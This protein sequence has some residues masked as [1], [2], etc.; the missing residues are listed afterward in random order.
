[1]ILL[2]CSDCTA[3][4]SSAVCAAVQTAVLEPGLQI[5]ADLFLK[6]LLLQVLLHAQRVQ[7]QGGGEGRGAWVWVCGRG[8]GGVRGRWCGRGGCV[9]VRVHVACDKVSVT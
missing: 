4:Y 7:G 2:I 5:S 9:G 8:R 1:M 3:Q 6:Q